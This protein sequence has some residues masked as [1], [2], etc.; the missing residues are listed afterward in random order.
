[1]DKKA[2]AKGKQVSNANSERVEFA[3]EMN[4]TSSPKNKKNK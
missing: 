3:E 4:A 2:K 1:M